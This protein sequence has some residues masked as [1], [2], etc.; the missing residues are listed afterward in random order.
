MKV[1]YHQ[2]TRVMKEYD[3]YFIVLACC[4]TG[5][6][7]VQLMEG[8]KIRLCIEAFNRFLCEISVPKIF[9]TDTE[10][11]LLKSLKEFV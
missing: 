1:G 9:L 7:N 10:G 2:E 5:T 11:F 6:V 8:T 4:A 3:V